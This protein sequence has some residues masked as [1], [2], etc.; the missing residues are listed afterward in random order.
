MNIDVDTAFSSYNS[1][2]ESSF[3]QG[4]APG[5]FVKF[6][7]HMIQRLS[8]G[9][10]PDRLENYLSWHRE[11]KKLLGSG[12]TISDALVM[13]FEEASAWLII[14][15]PRILDLFSGELGNPEKA[16]TSVGSARA[17]D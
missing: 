5:D 9:E 6:G 1:R 2:F 16:V 11:C 8:V 7:N 17:T 13:E 14:E 4:K 12:H 10:F 15:P 3:G